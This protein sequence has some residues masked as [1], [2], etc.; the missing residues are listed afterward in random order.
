LAWADDIGKLWVA[1]NTGELLRE[2]HNIK[3]RDEF[4]RG[5]AEVTAS[6]AKKAE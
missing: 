3:G 4:L 2:R 1:Y 6:F 5:M